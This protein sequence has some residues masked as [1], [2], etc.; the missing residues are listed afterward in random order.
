MKNKKI[1]KRLFISISILLITSILTSTSAYVGMMKI[2]QIHTYENHY[3][4]VL[5]RE[6]RKDL[7]FK[8]KKNQRIDFSNKPNES[9]HIPVP[10]FIDH[11]ALEKEYFF[12]VE[13]YRL[14]V[15]LI[16][17]NEIRYVKDY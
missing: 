7:T 16:K 17:K 13:F 9:N 12:D 3:E 10:E 14:P 5:S 8:L 1:K 2:K 11:L 6:E 4:I 15:S